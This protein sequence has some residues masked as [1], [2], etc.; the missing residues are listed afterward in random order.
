MICILAADFSISTKDAG[1][2]DVSIQEKFIQLWVWCAANLL[3]QNMYIYK[4][5]DP[6]RNFTLKF[7]TE[8]WKMAFR[9]KT[10]KLGGSIEKQPFGYRSI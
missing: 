8:G 1:I 9:Y 5:N 2:I 6:T 7:L 10:H 3:L 4:K